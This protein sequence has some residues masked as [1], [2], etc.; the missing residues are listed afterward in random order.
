MTARTKTFLC[1]CVCP[2][3]SQ[4]HRERYMRRMAAKQAKM[5]KEESLKPDQPNSDGQERD[6][7]IVEKIKVQHSGKAQGSKS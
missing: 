4:D 1:L 2:F 7:P 5:E 6:V 3:F